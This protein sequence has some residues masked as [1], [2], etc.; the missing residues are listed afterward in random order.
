MESPKSNGLKTR[1][2]WRFRIH[3]SFVN[4]RDFERNQKP[5]AS[6]PEESRVR[7]PIWSIPYFAPQYQKQTDMDVRACGL[8]ADEKLP[9][10]KLKHVIHVRI[11][12]SLGYRRAICKFA[13]RWHGAI[14][15]ASAGGLHVTHS[16]ASLGKYPCDEP[17]ETSRTFSVACGI[18]IG[19]ILHCGQTS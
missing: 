17:Q 13:W 5:D 8:P 14:S 15:N 4:S 11:S 1:V 7:H 18:W 6:P 16:L 3:E 19:S 2:L 10:P 9:R 12:F